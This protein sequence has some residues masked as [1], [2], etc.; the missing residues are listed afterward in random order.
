MVRREI[1]GESWI[2]DVN[3]E[4]ELHDSDI[5]AIVGEPS[6]VVLRLK[7]FVH[8]S[9]G[10]P[11]RSAGTVW[12][13]VAELRFESGRCSHPLPQLPVE[14]S[15]GTLH[16]G[17]E[18]FANVFPS[19]IDHHGSTRLAFELLTGDTFSVE[20]SALRVTLIDTGTYIED[21]SP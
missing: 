20:G 9:D 11:G 18:R 21:F 13:H 4:I 10:A 12:I 14:I 3:R 15:D 5:I 17:T 8:Y 7:A 2:G 1:S 16:L 6:A 19:E